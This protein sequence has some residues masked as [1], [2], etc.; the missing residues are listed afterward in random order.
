[1][2]KLTLLFCLSLS[3]IAAA[4]IH[5]PVDPKIGSLQADFENAKKL[6]VEERFD[7]A[8]ARAEEGIKKLRELKAAPAGQPD[9]VP[10]AING[11]G[12]RVVVTVQNQGNADVIFTERVGPGAQ[13]RKSYTGFNVNILNA[14]TGRPFDPNRPLRGS[15]T[16]SLPPGQTAQVQIGPITGCGGV[17]QPIFAEVDTRATE[18]NTGNNRTQQPF[19]V[20][21]GPCGS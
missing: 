20:R 8:I 12:N 4:Q 2:K 3:A 10:I 21:G 19:N 1:M 14:N 7:E 5:V 11:D 17:N 6:A 9:L 16:G 13:L 18:S 15:F